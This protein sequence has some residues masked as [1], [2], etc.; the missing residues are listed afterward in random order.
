MP[1]TCSGVSPQAGS[2]GEGI[3]RE[4]V[5]EVRVEFT[6]KQLLDERRGGGSLGAVPC[7]DGGVGGT[8]WRASRGCYGQV[9]FSQCLQTSPAPR[10]LLLEGLVAA[11][12][13]NVLF[14]PVWPQTGPRDRSS[15]ERDGGSGIPTGHRVPSHAKG[16]LGWPSDS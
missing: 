5:L 4:V 9:P 10:K 14:P 2:G 6:V 1:G 16:T 8:T 11:L 7:R 3:W 15:R 13:L 12:T